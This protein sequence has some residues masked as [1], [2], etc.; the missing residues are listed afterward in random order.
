MMTN[1]SN[2]KTPVDIH[3]LRINAQ[4]VKIHLVQFAGKWEAQFT[5]FVQDFS[6]SRIESLTDFIS[7]VNDGLT[8]HSPADDP[9]NEKLLYATMTHIRD[10]KLAMNAIKLLF[11]PIREQVT[12][13]KKHGV[14]LSEER[15]LELEQAPA[16]YIF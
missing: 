6:N 13:L 4:P 3:W 2:L 1:I 9:E 16:R 11:Q 15:L 10:V 8:K 7:K 12:L 5:N 14:S